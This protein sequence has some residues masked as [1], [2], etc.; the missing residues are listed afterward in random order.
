M[1]WMAYFKNHNIILYISEN[2][3]SHN[4]KDIL[5]DAKLVRDLKVSI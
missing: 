4:M 1:G 5:I 2:N 3:P